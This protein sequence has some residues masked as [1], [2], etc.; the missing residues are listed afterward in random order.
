MKNLIPHFIQDQFIVNNREGRLIAY[1]LFVDLSGFTQV[2]GALMRQGNRGAEELSKVLNDIFEPLVQLVYAHEGFIPYFAGDAFAAIFTDE[3]GARKARDVVQVALEAR[4]LFEQREFQFGNFTIGIRF[5]LSHGEVEWGIVGDNDHAFYFKGQPIDSCA[6]CQ[7][8][9]QDKEIVID[10]ALQQ[11]LA[12]GD[13]ILQEVEPGYCRI[14]S[15]P[16]SLSPIIPAI[17]PTIDRNIAL[18]FLPPSVVDYQHEGEFRTVNS[19]FISFDGLETYESLNEFS[20]I[21]LSQI[22]SFSGY[23]KEIDFGDKGGVLTCFFGAPISFENSQERTLEFVLSLQEALKGLELSS[24]LRYRVGVSAG[25]AY[26]GTVG[27]RERCQY[28]AVGNKVNLA[29]RLMTYAD[30]GDVLVDEDI[31]KSRSFLFQHKGDIHYKGFKGN[32]PTFKLIGR[33]YEFTSRDYENEMIGRAEELSELLAFAQPV[34]ENKFAGIAYVYGEAGIGKSRLI[35]EFKKTLLKENLVHWFTCQA[36]QI[37]KKPFNPFVYFLRNYFKQFQES[38][39]LANFHQF[40]GRYNQLIKNLAAKEGYPEKEGIIRELIRTKAVLA[41]LIGINIQNSI[42]DQLDARGRYQNT[43]SAVVTLLVAEAILHPMVLAIEDGHWLDENSKELLHEIGRNIARYP[44]LIV[45]TSRYQDDGSKPVILPK[46]M[47]PDYENRS[48]EINLNVLPP[49]GIR[50]FAE[51]RLQ[52]KI[53]E[54]FFEL[55]LRTSNSNPFYLEQILEY[56]TESNLIA[57]LDGEWTIKDKNIKLSNSINA[58]LTARIDRLST[59][60]KETVKA[61]AVIGREFELPILSEVMMQQEEFLRQ[62]GGNGNLLKE[63]IL[64][65]E[66]WQ[67]WHAMN[68]LRYIFRHSLMREAAYSMQLQTR[69]QQLHKLIAEAIEHLYKENLETRYADLAYHYE[70]AGVFDKTCEYLRKAADFARSNYQNQQALEYYEKLLKKLGNPDDTDVQISTHLKKGKVLE[71]IG[72][73]D[74]CE[75]A[76]EQ[77][78]KLAKKSRDVLLLGQA[79]NSLGH[80]LLLKGEYFNAMRFLQTAAG[81]FESID[82]KVGIA[83]VYGNLGDLHFR[84]G[85]YKE[86]KKYFEQSLG[87]GANYNAHVAANLGLNYMN[88]GFY[89]EGISCL[90]PHLEACIR[91]NDKQGMATLYTNMGIIFSEKGDYDAALESYE[92]GLV[93]SE[94]L[95][96]KLLTAI[97]IG[98]IGNI[99][100]HKGDYKTAKDLFLRD[101]EIAEELGDKQGVAIALG[102]IGEL[103]S[104]EGEFHK[105]IDY[106]QKNL[107]LCEELGYQKGIAKALNTLGDVF[108]FMGEFDRSMHFYDR[109]IEV[110]RKIN[111]KLVLGASLVEKGLVLIAKNQLEQLPAVLEEALRI[112]QELGN[113][114]LLF[115]ARLLEAKQQKVLGQLEAAENL[116]LKFDWQQLSSD[117][118][119]SVYF[120]L[121]QLRPHKQAYRQQALDLYQKLYKA[122]PKYMYR[123]RLAMLQ[124]VK[125]DV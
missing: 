37:L 34:F 81:L 14:K 98:S 39:S 36:D 48:L 124:G 68:E 119:A 25:T 12:K 3:G 125:V 94:E 64:H 120:E 121:H 114:D 76:Y 92:K 63:Q 116:L 101:L 31:Q 72:Q 66:K 71:L 40:E 115:D 32:V 123:I 73:W 86:A 55:L 4:H 108:Y 97:A 22:N 53:S 8:I 7:V 82:D 106:L 45:V 13:F 57:K 117:Q 89:D 49:E 88:Q 69:L 67:I 83:K 90:Q 26:T 111:N 74:E 44:V 28:A 6:K 27:G 99:H 65:A 93:L 62:N 75:H 109:A 2:T 96:N 29:A 78:L 105:S 46:G 60:V 77:A 112:A 87:I 16:V 35:Y 33:N 59:L 107:M 9:A 38:S 102:L 11:K 79:N 122:T 95:G 23:F 15:D 80:L 84:Q 118:Q 5:G 41:A 103:L 10:H 42:W 20:T 47:L 56:F 17:L 51:T 58:I 54:D 113:P 19:V 50:R 52:G 24:S 91:K 104:I 70:Q 43:L 110:T 21:V 30:W 61:A 1:T 85:E 100:M 18:R